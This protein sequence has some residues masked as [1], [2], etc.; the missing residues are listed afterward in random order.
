MIIARQKEQENIVEYILY[1]WQVEDL[2]RAHHFDIDA[3]YQNIIEKFQVSQESKWEMKAWYHHLIDTMMR[4]G[5]S[6]RGHLSFVRDYML[7]LQ[8]VHQSLIT[9]IQDPKYI[10]IYEKTQPY[11]LELYRKSGGNVIHETEVCLTALYGIWLMRLKKQPISEGTHQAIQDISRMMAY[12][13]RKFNEY[14]EGKLHLPIHQS[15]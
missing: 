11:I 12:L 3:I 13:A 4:E 1:M 7:R 15:N 9:L 14:R 5:I 8:Y 2:I 6:E 10:S